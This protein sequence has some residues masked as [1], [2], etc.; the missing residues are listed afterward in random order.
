MWIH[1]YPPTFGAVSKDSFVFHDEIRGCT[2][3]YIHGCIKDYICLDIHACM[4][5]YLPIFGVVS[6]ELHDEV[7]AVVERMRNQLGHSTTFLWSAYVCVCV[8]MCVCVFVCVC[9]CVCMCVCVYVR[10]CVCACVCVCLCVHIHAVVER[11]PQFWST[12]RYIYIHIYIYTYLYVCIY[13]C[14]YIYKHFHMCVY[15]YIYIY[16]DMYVHIYI[17]TYIYV[18]IDI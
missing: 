15:V 16:I 13:I 18:N 7:H 17:C 11:M 6:E 3:T 10:V 4:Y 12:R 2:Q 8:C 5:I 14:V 1:V 9:V